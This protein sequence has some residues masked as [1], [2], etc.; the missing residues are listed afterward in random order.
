MIRAM[1]YM[2]KILPFLLHVF[3]WNIFAFFC[4]FKTK[5]AFLAAFELSRK[6]LVYGLDDEIAFLDLN[7]LAAN[8]LEKSWQNLNI[9]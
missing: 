1:I 2:T 7:S 3:E 8:M 5:K 4:T 9:K 6:S